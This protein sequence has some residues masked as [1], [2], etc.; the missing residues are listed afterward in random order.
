M[1]YNRTATGAIS[2]DGITEMKT[3]EV[4]KV[5]NEDSFL[6]KIFLRDPD[7]GDVLE[8]ISCSP[9]DGAT[10]L[11]TGNEECKWSFTIITE[12]LSRETDEIVPDEDEIIDDDESED[13]E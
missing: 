11:I 9:V 3:A 8:V 5:L 4:L 7:S 1:V 13:E 12:E 10:V 6:E 2:R